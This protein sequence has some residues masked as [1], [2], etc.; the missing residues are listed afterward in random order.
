[1]FGTFQFLGTGA[2]AGVPVIGCS[3]EVCRSPSPKNKRFRP[4]GILQIGG[5]TIAIDMGPDFRSQ[6][7]AFGIHTLDGLILTHT[8]Y[9]HIAGIDEVR[10]FN[11]REKKSIPCLLSRDSFIE[12]QKRYYYF[13]NK[14]GL[15]AKLDFFPFDEERGEVDFLGLKVGFCNFY[16][17]SM[18]VSGYRVGD[19]AYITD[20]QK[21]D[22]SIFDE[23]KGVEQLVLS[24]LRPDASPFHLSFEEA[25]AFSKRV[26]PKQ[27]YITHVGHFLDHDAMNALLPPGV[28]VAY[29]GL[30]LEFQ[31]TN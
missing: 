31:C 12:L 23:L 15:S 11:V 13:F 8:H 25:I 21:Y 27:T 3:C 14:E 28:R 18:K 9:D 22:E 5:R 16:Q 4:S 30:K 6:A 26:K 29:D 10:I 20:I 2:S 19:F 24:A 1:M 17:A 7:L